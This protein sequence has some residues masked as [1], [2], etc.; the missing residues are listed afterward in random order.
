MTIYM[1]AI[2]LTELL[3]LTMSIHVSSYP[4][5]TRAEKRWYL[6]T[7]T[8]IFFCAG[9]E[10]ISVHFDGRGPAFVIPLTILD[11]TQ[12]SLSPMLPVFFVGALGMRRQ[13]TVAG[14]VF[15]LHALAEIVSAPFGWIF[16]YDAAGTYIRG[17]YYIIYEAF[18]IMSLVFLIVCLVIVGKRF[19]R[20][21]LFTIIMVFVVMVAAIIPLILFKVYTDYIGIGLC[22]SLCYIYYNDLIQ[23]DIQEKLVANQKKMQDM[24]EHTISGMANLIESRDL[25]TGE[26]VART[27]QYVRTLAECAKQD[28]VYSDV[29]NDRFISTLY[30]VAPMHDIGKIVVPDHILK[31]PGR[32][33]REEFEEIKR[34]AFE[35]GRV[36]R[37]V[38]S[39]VADEEY[40]A[41]ASDVA[42][43][44]HEYWNG[45][46]Y[47]AGLAGEAIPLCA[48]I[49]AIA[50][51]YDA[52]ISERCYK[53]PMPKENAFEIIRQESGTHFDPKLAQVFLNH[54]E[55][56]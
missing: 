19:K 53:K 46:G 43:Y 29:L 37:E 1:S 27:S 42:A 20:R 44:H 47:P 3:M 45:M 51:V 50:D 36:V 9:A 41:L 12:F 56:F 2:A 15:S 33:T 55:A 18:Y 7:F 24:Q 38:L 25:E 32:L 22:A 14:A 39:G 49:M 26:H 8:A 48:R 16:R 4:G 34:H 21:D 17:E 5:F 30:M 28:G 52:L 40:V 10:F 13:A 54:R 11:M 35:G 31:K 23:E 6:Y